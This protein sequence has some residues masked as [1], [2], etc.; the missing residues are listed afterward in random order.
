MKGSSADGADVADVTT[1]CQ[2][3]RM[4]ECDEID[5][6]S[7][8][9]L[10]GNQRKPLFTQLKTELGVAHLLHQDVERMRVIARDRGSDDIL[11]D[12]PNENLLAYVVHL[13]WSDVHS[14]N[15]NFP[16]TCAMSKSLL[17]PEYQ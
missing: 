16:I 12:D 13:T 11:V 10:E 8:E 3:R 5:W 7:W 2:N 4:R 15:E 9:L 1:K 6:Q 17:P 14:E